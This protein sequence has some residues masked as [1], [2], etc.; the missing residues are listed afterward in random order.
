MDNQKIKL[1]IQNQITRNRARLAQYVFENPNFTYPERFGVIRIKK[2]AN[3]FLERNGEVSRWVIIP[4]LSGMGKTTMLAQL[5]FAVYRKVKTGHIIYI[6]LDEVVE[7]LGAG[8][9]DVLTCYETILGV[10]FEESNEPIIILVDEAHRDP[11]WASVLTSLY[12]KAKNVFIVCSGSSAVLLQNQREDLGRRTIFEKLYP[13]CF[14]EFAMIKNN[15]FPRKNLKSALREAIYF[16][17]SA[18]DA[19]NKLLSFVPIVKEGWDKYQRKEIDNYLSTGSLPYAA[20]LQDTQLPKVLLG[21]DNQLEKIINRDIV[22]LG[23]FNADTISIIKRLL[24][25]IADTNDAVSV[26]KL[27]GVLGITAVTLA[28]ILEVLERAELIIRVLPYGSKIT[29]VKKPSKFLL[30]SPAIRRALLDVTGIEATF[31]T[32]KGLFLEDAVGLHLYREFV[33]ARNGTLSYDSAQGGADFIISIENFTQL[34]IE[35]GSGE[36]SYIQVKNTMTKIRC[37]YGIVISNSLL[38]HEDN[39]LK[40]PWEFFFLM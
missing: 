29:K 4:G 6:S 10:S 24:F 8:L 1:Y 26:N 33:A 31:Q 3:D 20:R 9:K 18:E 25:I 11:K 32:K 27:S 23:R 22:E 12:N 37:R 35:V 21:I 36:K 16:S 28:N 40:L 30:M 15:I 39:I 2:L 17:E 14:T 19:Y 5:Y 38:A 34:A 7:L 13:L